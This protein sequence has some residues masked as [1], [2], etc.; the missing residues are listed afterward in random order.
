MPIVVNDGAGSHRSMVTS[1]HVFSVTDRHDD[2]DPLNPR[3]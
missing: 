2:F 3:S 1:L